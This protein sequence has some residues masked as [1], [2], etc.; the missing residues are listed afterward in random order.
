MRR[1]VEVLIIGGGVV[2]C[3][4]AYHLARRGLRDVTVL[5]QAAVGSGSSGKAVGG[6]R[7]QFSTPVCVRLS[8]LSLAAFERFQAEMG[9]DPGL[10]QCG[11]LLVTAR[12]DVDWR[13]AVLHVQRTVCDKTGAVKMCK[14]GE[15][16]YVPMSR[17]LAVWLQE[18][19]ANIQL[20]G[21]GRPLVPQK[22]A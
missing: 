18:H 15:D 13:R 22:P 17:Q 11:Y 5:E 3:S 2:G 1:T 9:M 10:E 20:E 4:I 16:R 7:L 14:D 6:I 12:S 8:L 19:R 21:Q